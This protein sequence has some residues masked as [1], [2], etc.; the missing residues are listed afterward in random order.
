MAMAS[1]CVGLI[2]PGMIELPGSLAGSRNSPSPARGPQPSSRMS[3]AM[4]SKATA[5][6]RSCPIA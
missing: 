6:P 4:R 5:N 2:F 3:L 1:H